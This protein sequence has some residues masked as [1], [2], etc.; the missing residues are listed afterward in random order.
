VVFEYVNN[1]PL[2]PDERCDVLIGAE[3]AP[4]FLQFGELL[5]RDLHNFLRF[6]DSVA[7]PPVEV[8]AHFDVAL[9]ELNLPEEVVGVHLLV[10]VEVPPALAQ[11]HVG[12]LLGLLQR[13]DLQEDPRAVPVGHELVGLVEV[14]DFLVLQGFERFVEV[15]D[16]EREAGV[17]VEDE[18][19]DDKAQELGGRRFELLYFTVHF[20]ELH[21]DALVVVEVLVD[22]LADLEYLLEQL[23]RARKPVLLFFLH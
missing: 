9:L 17:L 20:L 3:L 10:E 6:P 23:L 5:V 2:V 15:E 12:Q 7:H 13:V 16:G 14:P 11:V 22:E 21:L 1:P 18:R 19:R 8:P 4:K